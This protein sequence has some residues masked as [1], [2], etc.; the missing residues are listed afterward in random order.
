ML[1]SFAATAT[2]TATATDPSREQIP[3]VGRTRAQSPGG[4]AAQIE[5]LGSALSPDRHP[6][7]D[8]ETRTGAALGGSP[9]SSNDPGLDQT[10]NG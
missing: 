9:S 1:P 10:A 5:A 3:F 6:G 8:P 7:L 2:A 4:D